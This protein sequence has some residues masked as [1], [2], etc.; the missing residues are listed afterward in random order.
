MIHYKRLSFI[1]GLAMVA[2]FVAV[3][4]ANT[5]QEPFASI[6]NIQPFAYA[7]IEHKGPMTDIGGV[8][9]Q[10][11]QAMQGQNVFSTVRGPMI[12][13]YYNSPGQVKPEELIWEVGFPVIEQTA[14]QAPLIK[15]VWKHPTVAVAL[16]VGPYAKTGETIQ[17]LMAW[18]G[19]K[20]Y[21]VDGPMLE[22]YLNNPMQVKPE[23]L[24][25]EIW[26]PVKKK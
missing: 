13:V 24:Q 23:E 20:G 3:S 4:A 5:A 7:C 19:A 15:K 17:K 22:R 10:L 12:G 25:T 14:P 16:H 11:M 6:K 2:S 18:V 8:I 26:I 1:V 9:S 21:A